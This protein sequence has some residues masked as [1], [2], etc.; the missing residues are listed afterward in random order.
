MTRE[1]VMCR[2]ERQRAAPLG[3]A[4]RGWRWGRATPSAPRARLAAP[5]H[6]RAALAAIPGRCALCGVDL[7]CDAVL[8]G[9]T[10]VGGVRRRSPVRL[11]RARHDLVGPG[12]AGPRVVVLGVVA[13]AL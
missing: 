1:A 13:A 9:R 3:T 10:R 6:G 4:R 8:L 2:G 12:R 5:P 7:A 11:P